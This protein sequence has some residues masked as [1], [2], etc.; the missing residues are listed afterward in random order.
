MSILQPQLVDN[1]T[2]D[3]LSKDPDLLF[4][5]DELPFRLQK[6]YN[7]VHTKQEV[8]QVLYWHCEAGCDRTGEASGAYYMKYLNYNVTAAFDRDT[9]ECGRPPNYFSKGM[10]GWFC[11]YLEEQTGSDY[12]NCLDF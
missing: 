3:D 9:R 10:I 2:R 7:W 6:A 1:K 5:I 11:L 8:P 4:I 12:G